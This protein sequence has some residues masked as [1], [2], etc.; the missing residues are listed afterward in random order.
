MWGWL[1][2][3]A[4]AAGAVE[5]SSIGACTSTKPALPITF[6]Y[7]H[8]TCMPA[9]IAAGNSSIL[10]ACSLPA[11]GKGPGWRFIDV[12]PKGAGKGAAMEYVRT[13]LGFSPDQTVAC[14]DSN[15]DLLM[16]DAVGGTCRGGCAFVCDAGRACVCAEGVQHCTSCSCAPGLSRR[17]NGPH[18]NVP[19]GAPYCRHTRRLRWATATRRCAHGR[20]LPR[21]GQTAAAAWC[22]QSHMLPLAYW[23]DSRH[24][25]L[26]SAEKRCECAVRIFVCACLWERVH[27]F[28]WRGVAV[29]AGGGRW[30]VAMA[31]AQW[32]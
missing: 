11:A 4:C 29:S 6:P 23:R 5:G 10:E 28:C 18:Y 14:G 31:G 20:R 25:I 21:R 17:G 16:L 32:A 30:A 1:S 13:K 15:N 2:R 3:A 26:L 24:W 8:Y 12:V 7:P 19:N 27:F 9:P 22:L